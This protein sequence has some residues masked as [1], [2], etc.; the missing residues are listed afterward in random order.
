MRGCFIVNL[1]ICRRESVKRVGP[2]SVRQDV[3]RVFVLKM[4]ML[5][6]ALQMSTDMKTPGPRKVSIAV[7]RAM[8]VVIQDTVWQ[9]A[10]LEQLNI[11]T[12][13]HQLLSRNSLF[14]EYVLRHSIDQQFGRYDQYKY[15]DP[16]VAAVN[17]LSKQVQDLKAGMAAGSIV[18]PLLHEYQQSQDP[19]IKS[20][21][22]A[23]LKAIQNSVSQPPVLQPQAVQVPE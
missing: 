18:Q 7:R 8:E 21:L 22:I 10:M 4:T 19:E 11:T 2:C 1:W 16:H 9:C 13:A 17:A 3:L 20:Q 15:Q 23:T 14:R 12:P 5:F 6:T